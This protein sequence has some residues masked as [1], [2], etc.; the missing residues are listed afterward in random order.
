M[1]FLATSSAVEQ[2][3][4]ENVTELLVTHAPTPHALAPE[5]HGGYMTS[6]SDFYKGIAAY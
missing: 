5:E 4:N 1:E 2:G 6:F 3:F